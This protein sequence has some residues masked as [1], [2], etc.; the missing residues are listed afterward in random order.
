MAKVETEHVAYLTKSELVYSRLR[1]EIL[2]GELKQETRLRVSELA[3]RFEVSE[4]PIREALRLLQSEGLVELPSHKGAIVKRLTWERAYELVMIRMQLEMLASRIV[5]PLHTPDTLAPTDALMVQLADCV[6]AGDARGF[7]RLNR[8]FHRALYV[9]CPYGTL[10]EEIDSHWDRIWQARADLLLDVLDRRMGAAQ[11][12][13]TT[14]IDAMRARD[15]DAAE[16]AAR[17]HQQNTLEGWRAMAEA[18][19]LLPR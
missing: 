5:A 10:L 4:T 3:E 19:D 2:R 8:E 14:L 11:A 7:S 1:E 17:I 6:S 18:A 12:E 13:H 9:P 16:A 15:A